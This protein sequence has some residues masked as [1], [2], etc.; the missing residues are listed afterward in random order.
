METQVY[1]DE[2]ILINHENEIM[3]LRYKNDDRAT[4]GNLSR[5]ATSFGYDITHDRIKNS[6]YLH[7]RKDVETI[8][9]KKQIKQ[10]KNGFKY[11]KHL[12]EWEEL[13]DDFPSSGSC[14]LFYTSFM[15]C[16]L[17]MK[18]GKYPKHTKIDFIKI[19]FVEDEMEFGIYESSDPDDESIR[20]E[21]YPLFSHLFPK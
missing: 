19:N 14:N 15:G 21:I 2:P 6:I 9:S 18:I 10:L 3:A 16:T 11:L 8:Y 7:E 5:Y 13:F 17:K 4:F 20:F 1:L 12:F